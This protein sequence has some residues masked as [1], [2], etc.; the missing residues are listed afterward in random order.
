VD[1]HARIKDARESKEQCRIDGASHV[2][3]YDKDPYVTP[4]I[5]KLAELFRTSL[6][7]E[8]ARGVTS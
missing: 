6:G 3:L 4:A 1:D 2:V 8:V 7:D 5:A